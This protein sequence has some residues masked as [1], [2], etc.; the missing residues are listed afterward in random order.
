[1]VAVGLKT[2][3]SLSAEIFSSLIRSSGM[4]VSDSRSEA[5]G[6]NC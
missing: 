2:S 1:V 3:T 6:E 5:V 4:P